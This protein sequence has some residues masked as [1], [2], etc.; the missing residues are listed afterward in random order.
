MR[1]AGG[2]MIDLLATEKSLIAP[3]IVAGST[4][5]DFTMGNGHDTLWLSRAV[6]DEGHVFA[7]DVQQQALDNTAVLLRDE[8]RENCTLILDSH[9]NVKKY[10]TGPISAGLFNLGWL[11]GGDKSI[12]TLRETTLP[13]IRDAIDLLDH[14]GAILVAVYPGHEEGTA[15]GIAVG[16]M[17]AAYD[18]HEICCS[19]LR[20]IN[21]PTSPF[22]FLV[23]KK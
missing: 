21:S 15:E 6:G 23:E 12:T 5:V 14:D 17:L 3:H 13:A 20:I 2:H 1:H 22:F 4:V 16:E 8:G 9:S 18:R 10:V 7:F 19:Q 11:P